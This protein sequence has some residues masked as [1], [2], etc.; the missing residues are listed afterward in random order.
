MIFFE[1]L[2]NEEEL[3]EGD[4]SESGVDDSVLDEVVG[5]G[6]D[7]VE[8]EPEGFGLIDEKEEEKKLKKVKEEEDDELPEEED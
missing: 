4:D 1:Y 2:R 6:E 3:E 5:D 7:D 8:Q